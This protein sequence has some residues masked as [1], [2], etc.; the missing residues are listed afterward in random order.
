MALRPDRREHLAWIADHMRFATCASK[1]L[2]SAIASEV[3]P[4]SA[5]GSDP[6]SIN[7]ERLI[8]A[9][10]WADTAL[11]LIASGLPQW[12]LRRLIYDDGQWHCAL[13]LRREFPEWLDDGIETHNDDLALA[14]L[15]GLI[16]AARQQPVKTRPPTAPR[17]R[18]KQRDPVCC[19][20]FA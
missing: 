17:I 10:A 1:E 5:S 3:S 6:V 4:E 12:K 11:A 18:I 2:V 15:Q 7:I 8:A 20:N 9:G 16:E 14:L 13:S 19:D